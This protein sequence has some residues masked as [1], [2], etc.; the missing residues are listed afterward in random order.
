MH[1]VNDY[2]GSARHQEA[3]ARMAEGAVFKSS[4]C[5]DWG[6]TRQAVCDLYIQPDC[7]VRLATH[8]VRHTPRAVVELYRDARS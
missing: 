7:S 6:G 8:T 4:M 2:R 1:N 3:L 5:V